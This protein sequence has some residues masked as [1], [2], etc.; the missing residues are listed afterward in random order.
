MTK[1]AVPGGQLVGLGSKLYPSNIQRMLN[2]HLTRFKQ[3]LSQVLQ[4]HI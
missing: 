4:N 3:S 2:K 1:I